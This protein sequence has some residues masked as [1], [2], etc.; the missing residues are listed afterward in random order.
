MQRLGLKTVVL[1]AT[2]VFK[3][4]KFRQNV[5]Y[6]TMI[7][8]HIF[9]LD[10][11]LDIRIFCW[12]RVKHSSLLNQKK[13]LLY[14][15][16]QC[17]NDSDPQKKK[18]N[19]TWNSITVRVLCYSFLISITQS[20]YGHLVISSE[21]MLKLQFYERFLLIICCMAWITSLFLIL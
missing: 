5:K 17:L 7:L 2:V 20:C 18:K 19:G 10:I 13:R 1:K 12:L 14:V 9:K 6:F 3:T 11:N 4:I 8:K 16:S 15:M 21:Q